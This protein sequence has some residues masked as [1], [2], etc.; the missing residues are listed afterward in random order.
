LFP[1]KSITYKKY[2][3]PLNFLVYIPETVRILS[4]SKA[5]QGTDKMKKNE[6]AVMVKAWIDGNRLAQQTDLSCYEVAETLGY[7]RDTLGWDSAVQGSAQYRIN[8]LA[9]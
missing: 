3:L 8:N 4:I 2:R 7:E 1:I 6:V 9:Y 5:K